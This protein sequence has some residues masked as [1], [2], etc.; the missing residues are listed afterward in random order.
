MNDTALIAEHHKLTFSAWIG[1]AIGVDGQVTSRAINAKR[2]ALP[3]KI[4]KICGEGGIRT[5]DTLSSI[6]TFQ[7]CSLNHSD[8][9]PGLTFK[10]GTNKLRISAVSN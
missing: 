4:G 9:S 5:R 2:I 8:T 7:A 6:H 3:K 10:W 1:K